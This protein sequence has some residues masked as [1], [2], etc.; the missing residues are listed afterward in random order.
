MSRSVFKCI[1]AHTCGNPV[2]LI[3]EGAPVLKGTNMSEKRQFF[4]NNF[5]WIRKGL[6]FEPRGH[7]MMSGAIISPPNNKENDFSILYIETSGCLPMCGLGTIGAV[8]IAIE[9]KV[10]LPK[11]SGKLSIETPAG[12]IKVKYEQDGDKVKSVELINVDSFLAAENYSIYSENLGDIYFDVAYGGNYYAIIEPQKN[13]SGIENYTAGNIISY[14]QE[15]RE[16]INNKYPNVFIHPEDSTINGVSHL[17][18]T[19]KTLDINSSSRNA[20]FYGDKAID[21]SPCGTGTSA[22]MAQLFHKGKLQIGEEFI[23]ESYIGSKFIG[24]IEKKS[25]VGSFNA[26]SPSVRGWAKVYGYNTIVIDDNDPYAYGFQ[27]I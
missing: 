3:V 10:I 26:I 15:I 11:N 13:F 23:H 4:L 2:R 21:R 17:L 20:V 18:W 8:T 27:V 25:K 12:L 19:G 9:E 1:D 24:K 6:M 22:R 5:D 7:D 16:K 14:S